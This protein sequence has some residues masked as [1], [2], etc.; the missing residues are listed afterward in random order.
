MSADARVCSGIPMKHACLLLLFSVGCA[1]SQA[2]VTIHTQQDFENVVVE[3]IKQVIDIFNTD[4]M[5][6]EILSGDLRDVRNSQK[7]SAAKEWRNAHP[8]AQQTAK[9]KVAEHRAEFEKASAAA[10]RQCGGN[11]RTIMNE[12]ME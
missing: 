8:E 7:L 2:K 11:L 5:N 1:G 10:N 3:L 12:L 6:C 4:G 9:E